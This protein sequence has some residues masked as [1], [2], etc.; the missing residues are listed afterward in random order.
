LPH[1]YSIAGGSLLLVPQAAMP[2]SKTARSR[3]DSPVHGN[4]GH[5]S[6]GVDPRTWFVIR[7]NR[8]WFESSHEPKYY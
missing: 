4:L 6:I 2:S 7:S 5:I 8:I 1:W 3:L